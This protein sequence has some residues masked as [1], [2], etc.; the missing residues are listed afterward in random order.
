MCNSNIAT[1][2]DGEINLIRQIFYFILIYPKLYFNV[3]M[4]LLPRNDS[5]G[6]KTHIFQDDRKVTDY[7]ISMMRLM[8]RE[9]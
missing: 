3:K 9:D 5:P 4:R 1:R 6:R 2:N 7:T 8:K